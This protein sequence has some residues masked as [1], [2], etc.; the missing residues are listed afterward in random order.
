MPV[1]VFVSGSCVQ[2]RKDAFDLDDDPEA[3]AEAEEEGTAAG[4]KFSWSNTDR[5]YTYEELLGEY[6]GRGK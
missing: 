3:A 5:E 1:V 4:G 6:R 2:D